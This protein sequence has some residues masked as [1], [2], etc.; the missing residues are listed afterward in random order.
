MAVKL[1]ACDLIVILQVTH[2]VCS[3][4]VQ[5]YLVCFFIFDPLLFPQDS[6]T[7]GSLSDPKAFYQKTPSSQN[8]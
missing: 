2:S 3:V 1:S 7:C 5:L 6:H 4:Q 8:L